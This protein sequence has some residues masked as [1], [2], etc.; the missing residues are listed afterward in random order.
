MSV[1]TVRGL[2]GAGIAA[3]VMTVGAVVPRPLGEPAWAPPEE[4]AAEAPSRR[5]LRRL[6]EGQLCARATG[7]E[8][9]ARMRL[10]EVI[11]EEAERARLDPL[12][13]LAIIEVESGWDLDA[14]SNRGAQGLMQLRPTTLLGEAARSGLFS[15]DLTDPALNVR[16][17]VRYFRRLLD[18]FR[19]EETALMAYNA[20]PA[21][22]RGYLRA[23]EVPERFRAYPRRVRHE[24][25]RLRR[26]LGPA[27]GQ[28]VAIRDRVGSSR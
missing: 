16:A 2:L 25:T 18:A 8:P 27:A 22:I 26:A 17:G 5:P 1:W 7:L 24:V 28:A 6:V 3:A 11:I 19:R 12:L 21:R 10:A 20:G 9:G 4:R 15:V 14:E 13:V 23:G